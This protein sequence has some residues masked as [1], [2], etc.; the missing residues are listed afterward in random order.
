MLELSNSAAI[1]QLGATFNLGCI[2]LSK[3]N[4]FAQSLSNFFF[5]KTVD[6]IKKN[7]DSLTQ[8]SA[9][10]KSLKELKVSADDEIKAKIKELKDDYT[11]T[12]NKAKRLFARIDAPIIEL[13][14]IC[15]FLGFYSVYVLM[16]IAFKIDSSLTIPYS[17]FN[18]ASLLCVAFFLIREIVYLKNNNETENSITRIGHKICVY[19]SISTL[20]IFL[21]FSLLKW[22]VFKEQISDFNYLD[23]FNSLISI[24]LPFV[25]F[26]LYF[27]YLL[28]ILHT[29]NNS[30]DKLF[31]EYRRLASRK[32]EIDE[33]LLNKDREDIVPI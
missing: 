9:K 3:E 11:S 29:V 31:P 13:D 8:F 10:F 19:L 14:N 6:N 18:I 32:I 27:F 17:V 5:K 33:M 16:L 20:C 1:I 21:L 15:F 26:V 23:T 25:G 7:E 4:S 12:N 24:L 30:T 22:F 28:Y 2:A